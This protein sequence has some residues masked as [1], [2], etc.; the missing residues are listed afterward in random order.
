MSTVEQ[1]LDAAT[2]ANTERAYAG[3]TRHFEVDW[4]GHLP[5]TADQV[6]RYLAAYAG[7]LAH[8]T[9]KHR[10]AALAQ[11]HHAH[12]FADPTRA[13]VVRKVLKGIQRS[14]EHTSELQSLM[15]ISY[16]VFCLKK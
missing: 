4:G 8:N 12:G 2:R 13:P 5:A 10:L 7:Q 14:E 3:A 9:L 1:Y 16:A 11:W 6:A 15:R